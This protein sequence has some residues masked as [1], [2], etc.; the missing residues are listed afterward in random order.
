MSGL[1]LELAR[2]MIDA[3]ADRHDGASRVFGGAA[4]TSSERKLCQ[5]ARSQRESGD[6]LSDLNSPSSFFALRSGA[7]VKRRIA[8]GTQVARASYHMG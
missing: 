3:V 4:L 5:S 2:P 7:G 6:R 8:C 1:V